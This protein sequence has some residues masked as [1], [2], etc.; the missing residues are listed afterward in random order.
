[1]L[2]YLIIAERRSLSTQSDRRVKKYFFHWSY[3]SYLQIRQLFRSGILAASWN[4]PSISSQSRRSA[5]RWWNSDW[6][7]KAETERSRQAE[8]SRSA[9]T[10]DEA[11]QYS[12]KRNHLRSLGA[13]LS[14]SVDDKIRGSE[15]EG[16][17]LSLALAVDENGQIRRWR[18]WKVKQSDLEG[19]DYQQNVLC[20]NQSITIGDG[21]QKPARQ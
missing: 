13:E 2:D 11:L 4:F 8:R 1:M 17:P 20:K 21:R 5:E 18:E 9:D 12:R 14:C 3:N 7:E 6:H 16:S 10:S 15:W 19:K